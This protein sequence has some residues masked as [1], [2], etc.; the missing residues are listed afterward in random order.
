M[1]VLL[2]EDE[3]LLAWEL[4]DMMKG[5]GHEVVGVAR[6]FRMAYR[7]PRGIDVAFVNLRLEDGETGR[8][9]AET[10]A[11]RGVTVVY[12]TALPEDVENDLGSAFGV[13]GK[14]YDQTMILEMLEAVEDH[15]NQSLPMA[16]G[17]R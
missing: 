13:I 11:L 16:V 7:A 14:P 2:V 4:T 8:D 15:R 5:A 6:N 12:L 3:F 9:I 1:N 17:F 10:L